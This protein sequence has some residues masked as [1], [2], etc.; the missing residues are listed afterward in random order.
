MRPIK[1]ALDCTITI[2][3]AEGSLTFAR[4]DGKITMETKGGYKIAVKN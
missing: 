2:P 3:F 4:K 1:C